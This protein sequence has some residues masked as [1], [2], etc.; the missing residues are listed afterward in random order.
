MIKEIRRT[1]LIEARK[2]AGMNQLDTAY[3]AGMSG[4]MY[5]R[6]EAGYSY[7]N[8]EAGKRIIELFHL[9]EDYFDKKS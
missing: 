7:P 9:P 1:E 3:M 4:S 6:I 5:Q 2:R 8:P